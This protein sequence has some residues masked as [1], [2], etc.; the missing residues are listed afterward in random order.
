MLS[1]G[2][3]HLFDPCGRFLFTAEPAA[4][5]D[6]SGGGGGDGDDDAGGDGEAKGASSPHTPTARRYSLAGTGA[7]DLL[8]RFPDQVGG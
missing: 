1:G 2:Q 4:D 8:R 3:F 7:E 6:G 5:A